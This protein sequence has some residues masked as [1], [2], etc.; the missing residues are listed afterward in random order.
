[1]TGPAVLDAAAAEH[2]AR[3]TH[4][5]ACE[6]SELMAFLTRSLRL[7]ADHNESLPAWRSIA[8]RADKLAA[9]LVCVLGGDQI[10]VRELAQQIY[11]RRAP[12]PAWLA[13]AGA[14][15]GGRHG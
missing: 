15:N 12:M 9:V 2:R 8:H 6:L 14:E 10:D 13:E 3:L 5:A 7:D 11:G 1:M 4:V